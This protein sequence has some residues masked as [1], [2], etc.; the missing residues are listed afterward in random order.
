VHSKGF[1]LKIKVKIL[2]NILPIIC[3]IWTKIDRTLGYISY[4][5][6]VSLSERFQYS[7]YTLHIL[8][9]N[10]IKIYAYQK[11]WFLLE[12]HRIS[13]YFLFLQKTSLKTGSSPPAW[14]QIPFIWIFEMKLVQNLIPTLEWTDTIT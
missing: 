12:Q 2:S 6:I 9:K 13:C 11:Q 5:G 14:C 8:T 10:K 7:R 4:K 3:L 1:K